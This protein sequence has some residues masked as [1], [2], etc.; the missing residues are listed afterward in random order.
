LDIGLSVAETVIGALMNVAIRSLP[1]DR[2]LLG[3]GF[4]FVGGCV[5]EA[6]ILPRIPRENAFH[7]PDISTQTSS[8]TFHKSDLVSSSSTL[9]DWQRR[10][11]RQAE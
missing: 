11:V 7:K 8:H 2:P 9:P 10:W 6:R 5:E 3:M 4:D 1:L